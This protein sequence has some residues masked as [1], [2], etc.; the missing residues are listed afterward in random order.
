MG[1]AKIDGY[2]TKREQITLGMTALGFGKQEPGKAGGTSIREKK[3]EAI[4][5]LGVTWVGDQVEARQGDPAFDGK[6]MWDAD[7]LSTDMVKFSIDEDLLDW[8][9]LELD[10][11]PPGSIGDKALGII[12]ERLIKMQKGTFRMPA[13]LTPALV[14]NG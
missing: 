6:P 14:A 5:Q 3:R 1:R 11:V 8:V 2:L 7:Q 9:V 4:D 10:K 12:E 13:E